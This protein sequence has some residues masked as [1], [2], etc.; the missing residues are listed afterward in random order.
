MRVVRLLSVLL[1][2][3]PLLTSGLKAQEPVD[4]EV[5][6][7]IRE[8]GLQ[9]SQVME[10][11]GYMSD[12]LGPRLTASPSMRAQLMRISEEMIAASWQSPDPKPERTMPNRFGPGS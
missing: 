9:R 3:L 8:E 12:V 7:K 5:V 2:V 6:S 1:V 11:V 4:W 10:M